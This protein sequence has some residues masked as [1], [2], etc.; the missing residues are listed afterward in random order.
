MKYRVLVG[1]NYPD[2]KRK[3]V[4]LRAE[5]GDLVDDLPARAVK[6]LEAAGI[7]EATK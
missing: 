2:P 7:I 5:P 4:E 6:G 3:D 1:I